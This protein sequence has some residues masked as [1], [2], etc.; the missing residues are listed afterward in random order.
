MIVEDVE[1]LLLEH[2]VKMPL[3]SQIKKGSPLANARKSLQKGIRL[4][5]HQPTTK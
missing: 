5:S 3:P 4:S 1:M 2:L